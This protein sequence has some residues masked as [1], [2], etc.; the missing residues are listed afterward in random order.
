MPEGFLLLATLRAVLHDDIRALT[1]R[2]TL[3][4]AYQIRDV[5][6][7]LVGVNERR[8][9]SRLEIIIDVQN[10]VARRHFVL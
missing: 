10:S 6:R 7:S 2:T 9:L 5:H 4:Q 8:I 3:L 1:L